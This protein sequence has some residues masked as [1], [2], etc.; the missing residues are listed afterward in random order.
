M[1]K[2]KVVNIMADRKQDKVIFQLQ[3]DPDLRDLFKINC[4][5][6]KQS[7]TDR[8]IELIEKD[9]KGK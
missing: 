2:W 8:M 6:Q 9:I 1:Y 3:L 5:K 7:M 4:I